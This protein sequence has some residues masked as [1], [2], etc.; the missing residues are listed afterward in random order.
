MK[1][2]ESSVLRGFRDAMLEYDEYLKTGMI[3]EISVMESLLISASA[4]H[5]IRVRGKA[6]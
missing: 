6:R 3:N 2:F 5:S 4:L 1:P